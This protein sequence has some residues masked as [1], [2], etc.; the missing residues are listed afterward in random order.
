MREAPVRS[1]D[2]EEQIECRN[3]SRVHVCIQCC[4]VQTN[5]QRFCQSSVN[6]ST[7][8]IAKGPTYR[9]DP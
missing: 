3:E 2:L 1:P 5:S 9:D 7:W 6:T 8:R 4:D